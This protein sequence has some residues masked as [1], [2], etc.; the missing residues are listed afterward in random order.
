LAGNAVA[1]G[2]ALVATARVDSA[3][4][5]YRTLAVILAIALGIELADVEGTIAGDASLPRLTI[6]ARR[7][8]VVT[9]AK[10]AHQ[11][12]IAVGVDDATFRELGR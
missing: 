3:Q 10:R 6:T 9:F 7:A 11:R 1:I 2:G 4:L 12:R 8:R 5:P